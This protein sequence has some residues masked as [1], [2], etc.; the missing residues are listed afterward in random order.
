MHRLIP[1]IRP[2]ATLEDLTQAYTEMSSVMDELMSNGLDRMN[3]ARGGFS[4]GEG[5]SG[6]FAGNI[7]GRYITFTST[8]ANID[9]PL[10]H[11]LGRT[12]IGYLVVSRSNAGTIYDSTT[13]WN[14]ASMYVRCDTTSCTVKLVAF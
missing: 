14:S 13:V 1:N 12:P 10:T 5:N 4:L 3:A 6:E 9:I 8:T 7:D 11:G 2:G